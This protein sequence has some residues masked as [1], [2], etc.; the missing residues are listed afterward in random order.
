[1]RSASRLLLLLP[2]LAT[3]CVIELGEWGGTKATRNAD[4]AFTP[5][6]PIQ[7]ILIDT[8]NG[9]VTVEATDAAEVVGTSKIWA[10]ASSQERAEKR[11]STMDWTFTEEGNGRVVLKM[12]KPA[13]GGSNN[14]GAS[15][16]VKVPVGARVLV[17]TGNGGVEIHGAF[18]YAWVDT[19][20]GSVVVHG[21]KDVAVDTSNGPVDVKSDGKVLVDTSNGGVR[22]AGSSTDF[23]LDSSNGDVEIALAGDWAGQ[24]VADTS[25][26]SITLNCAG[27]LQC[28]IQSDTS[29]GKLHVEGPQV[30]GSKGLLHLQTSNGSIWVK[31]GPK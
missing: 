21:A 3:S 23:S 19:S 30:A 22:Y 29:N 27:T 16:S 17:D 12:S 25:N 31:H 11:L 2:A 10:S 15:A 9:S 14:A 13:S 7:E 20:N 18:P 24:G 28:G 4:L 26:G 1:M 5:S 8:Y 6:A